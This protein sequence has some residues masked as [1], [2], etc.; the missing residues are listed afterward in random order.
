ML[1]ALSIQYSFVRVLKFRSLVSTRM[2][3]LEPFPDTQMTPACSRLAN[4]L[5]ML[6]DV[7][8]PC[9]AGRSMRFSS[10]CT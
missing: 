3:S 2:I 8:A 6:P 5:W 10:Y 7:R 9:T 4:T 1:S